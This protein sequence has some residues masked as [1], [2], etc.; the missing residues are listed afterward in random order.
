[1][2]WNRANDRYPRATDSAIPLLGSL[3]GLL[4]MVV[5]SAL[6]LKV[7]WSSYTCCT[8][9]TPFVKSGEHKRPQVVRKSYVVRGI[10]LNY[11]G[12]SLGGVA[13]NFLGNSEIA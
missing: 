7:R 13:D 11:A 2:R 4:W 1:M 8:L 12:F 10:W 6:M 9:A 3:V 5:V